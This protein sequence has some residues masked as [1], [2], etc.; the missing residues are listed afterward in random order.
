MLASANIQ[1]KWI[2]ESLHLVF[3]IHQVHVNAEIGG[4][5]Y[6]VHRVHPKTC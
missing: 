2:P 3:A 6:S 5:L 4:I 1:V